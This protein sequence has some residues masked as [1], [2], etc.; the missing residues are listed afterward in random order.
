MYENSEISYRDILDQ[1]PKS[2]NWIWGVL[3]QFETFSNKNCLLFLG[4]CPQYAEVT[5]GAGIATLDPKQN[6]PFTELFLSAAARAL[7]TDAINLCVRKE[8][9]KSRIQGQL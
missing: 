4:F 9:R 6:A 8:C 5:P 7:E 2:T 1:V 3:P